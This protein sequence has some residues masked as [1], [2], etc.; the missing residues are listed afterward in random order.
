MPYQVRATVSERLYVYQH[1]VQFSPEEDSW[2]AISFFPATLLVW[3]EAWVETFEWLIHPETRIDVTGSPWHDYLSKSRDK[4]TAEWDVLLL[5]GSQVTTH[6]EKRERL[7]EELVANL[8]QACEDN[9]WSLAIKLHPAESGEWYREQG[10]ERYIVEFDGIRDALNSAD[11]AVTHFSS[12][13]VESIALGT[14]IVLSETWSHG[15]SDLRPIAGTNFVDDNE[16]EQEIKRVQE[17]SLD[18]DSIIEDTRLLD[19][20]QSVD[21]ILNTVSE[22]R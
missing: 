11:I 21:R 9:G 13:F 18:S 15:L 5:G 8:I 17:S 16:I 7:Y 22:D 14:P 19:V 10:W 3:G 6:S 4:S 12:A 2:G 20:G 1:G